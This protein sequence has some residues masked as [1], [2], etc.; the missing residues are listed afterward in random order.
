MNTINERNRKIQIHRRRSV[1]E[2]RGLY[3]HHHEIHT[4]FEELIHRPWGMVRW[5]PAV[6]VHEDNDTF[7]IE[8]DLPGVKAEEI[9]VVVEGRTL[10][11][12]G[13]R[14]LRTCDRTTHVCERRD[15]R[16][17]RTFEFD[18]DIEERNIG[19]SWQDGVLTITVPKSQNA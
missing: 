4:M 3:V 18:G 14:Q 1:M 16:F 5:N 7:T 13:Q 15:G 19:S 17:A 8:M 10:A 11:I 9:R 2:R 6:D 12:E